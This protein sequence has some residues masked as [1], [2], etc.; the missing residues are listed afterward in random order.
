MAEQ[1]DDILSVTV[2][3]IPQKTVKVR[4]FTDGTNS[5]KYRNGEWE[6]ANL[7]SLLR[8]WTRYY[9]APVKGTYHDE[10]SETVAKRY[11]KALD[12]YTQSGDVISWSDDWDSQLGARKRR[13]TE[14]NDYL[15][16]KRHFDSFP[17][18]P[19]GV[20]AFADS[21]MPQYAFYSKINE[22]GKRRVYCSACGKT[23]TVGKSVPKH[24]EACTCRKCGAEVTWQKEW[25]TPRDPSVKVWT[26]VRK[27][28]DLYYRVTDILRFFSDEGK[29]KEYRHCDDRRMVETTENGRRKVYNYGM[30]C[31]TYYGWHWKRFPFNKEYE[32]DAWIFTDNLKEVLGERYCNVD[33]A[34]F[35]SIQHEGDLFYLLAALREKKNGE[36]FAKA[37]MWRLLQT[38]HTL[39]YDIEIPSHLRRLARKYD[40]NFYELNHLCKSGVI[41]DDRFEAVRKIR[42]GEFRYTDVMEK[43]GIDKYIRLFGRW[44]AMYPKNTCSQ[45][46]QW[47]KDYIQMCDELHVDI[48]NK[49]VKYPRELKE[50]HDRLAKRVSEIRNEKENEHFAA[51]CEEL[52]RGMHGYS[53][54]E[55]TV[56]FPR[57]RTDLIAEGQSLNH[58]VGGAHY[59]D[60]HLGGEKMIFFIRSTEAP[61]KPLYT[62]QANVKTGTICQ[63]YGYGDKAAPAVVREFCERFLKQLWTGS[64]TQ[65]LQLTA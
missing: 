61:D 24:K 10:A 25:Y 51:R 60:T 57:L 6:T 62:L 45:I 56:V 49:S 54:K 44:N 30:V 29:K 39:S 40:V 9:Y 19:K 52:Y 12:V 36:Y 4:Y 63:L 28:G 46:E 21:K 37:G 8:G 43:M 35:G 26:L 47:Y 2:Y 53:S 65:K 7:S 17:L 5:I 11:F 41:S 20:D 31:S 42:G 58:C 14:E 48:R 38:Q 18:L 13:T 64:K 1:Y 55:Y 22:R 50:A 23:Y 34:A 16:Q 33:T 15:R 32:Y 27:D 3:E 59:R